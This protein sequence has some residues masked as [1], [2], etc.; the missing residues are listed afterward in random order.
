MEQ[1]LKELMK[2]LNKKFYGES[3]LP[4]L[5]GA[6]LDVYLAITALLDNFLIKPL[7]E[8]VNDTVDVDDF[9]QISKEKMRNCIKIIK[10]VN[11]L[12]TINKTEYEDS[13][14]IKK[15]DGYSEDIYDTY[16]IIIKNLNS[17]NARKIN[18]MIFVYQQLLRFFN[19]ML[20]NHSNYKGK[21]VDVEKPLVLDI[22]IVDGENFLD[23]IS[24]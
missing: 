23:Y 4:E 5:D 9:I 20:L 1:Q 3:Q 10:R 13:G 19:N 6:F 22:Y 11:Y 14:L 16:D 8:A 15:V 2:T 17:E 7:N 24:T 12:L 21:L 18:N